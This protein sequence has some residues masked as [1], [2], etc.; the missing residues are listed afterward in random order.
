VDIRERKG[1]MIPGK[2]RG[3]GEREKKG[4]LVVV[5]D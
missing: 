2:G 4:G 5:V 3:E 1:D